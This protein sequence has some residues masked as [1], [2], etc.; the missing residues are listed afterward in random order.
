M[1]KTDYRKRA[2]EKIPSAGHL[3]L[4]LRAIAQ[5]LGKPP[6]TMIMAELSKQNRAHSLNA[7]YAV[8]GSFLNALKRAKLKSRYRQE[9]YDRDRELMLSE[10]RHLRKRLKRPIYDRDVDEARRKGLI[11]SPYHFLR[12]FGSV[13]KAIAAA[14]AGHK[15]YNRKEMIEFLRKLDAKLARPVSKDDI[16]EQFRAGKGPSEKAIYREFGGI[17]NARKIAKIRKYKKDE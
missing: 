11:S 3:I 8:F 12:A 14:E 17:V 10:L 6:T 1:S 5:K 9:F 15:K 4:E 13:A 2:G 7:Y 16:T